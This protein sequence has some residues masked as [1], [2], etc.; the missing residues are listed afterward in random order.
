MAKLKINFEEIEQSRNKKMTLAEV[1]SFFSNVRFRGDGMSF[2]CECPSHADN[3]NSLNVTQ[4]SDG[5]ILMKCHAGCSAYDIMEETGLTR[6]NLGTLKEKNCDWYSSVPLSN[7]N[8]KVVNHYDYYNETGIYLFT[9]VRIR[10]I[11]SKGKVSK[12]FIFGTVTKGKFKMSSGT[13]PRG[14]YN[15]QDVYSAKKAARGYANVYLVEGE[16][17]V[18]N[19]KELGFVATTCGGAESWVHDY[20]KHFIGCNVHIIRD[21]D[22]AGYKFAR[23]VSRSLKRVAHRVYIINPSDKDKGD[24]TD[25][26]EA[27]GD[28][29]REEKIAQVKNIIAAEKAGNSLQDS[30]PE[31]VTLDEKGREKGV[32]NDILAQCIVDNMNVIKVK[33]HRK[34]RNSEL[35]YYDNDTG[36]YYPFLDDGSSSSIV[37][38]Y[39]IMGTS[40]KYDEVIRYMHILIDRSRVVTHDEINSDP[41]RILFCNGIYNLET[42]ELEPFSPKHVFTRRLEMD[43]IPLSNFGKEDGKYFKRFMANMLKDPSRSKEDIRKTRNIMLETIGLILSNI[44]AY[45]V[46][47]CIIMV[48][49]GNT[50]K[51]KMKEL[52]SNLLKADGE[53]YTNASELSEI[54]NN[55]FIRGSLAKNIRMAGADDMSSLSISD[56]STFKSLTGGGEITAED[57]GKDPFTFIFKG[58]FWMCMNKIPRLPKEDAVYDRLIIIECTNPV[59]REK[60]DPRL[61]YKMYEEKEYIVSLCMKHLRNLINR[62]FEYDYC[63]AIDSSMNNYVV[64]NDDVYQFFEDT[65]TSTEANTR[66]KMRDAYDMYKMWRRDNGYKSVPIKFKD[67][68]HKIQ[69]KYLTYR[70][71]P[72][73]TRRYPATNGNPMIQGYRMI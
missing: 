4:V 7:K 59:P 68:T 9:K 34:S 29:K 53:S 61:G 28:V 65:F 31:W 54:E 22:E 56:V 50:G 62:G 1:A 37:R 11:D 15:I 19:L 10:T 73:G 69:E 18:D 45:M 40:S 72:D 27:L 36:M 33:P 38:D 67:F 32:S 57:K 71:R 26:I 60:K 3:Q 17:D 58:F 63:E 16:K 49:A 13:R 23:R 41:N 43:Y 46:K 51:S 5:S 25:Y 64:D 6:V 39:Q 21:N 52:I 35:Y 14:M 8:D 42:D 47:K 12:R 24:I 70:E 55:K 44:P 2:K 48:G 20:S 66:I 30:I